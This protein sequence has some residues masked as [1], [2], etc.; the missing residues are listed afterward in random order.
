MIVWTH[1]VEGIVCG[2]V[3]RCR[4]LDDDQRQTAL[5]TVWLELPAWDESRPIQ[6][7]LDSA[8]RRARADRGWPGEHPAGVARR[9]RAAVI[10]AAERLTGE[11]SHRASGPPRT[12]IAREQL[13]LVLADADPIVAGYSAERIA[14]LGSSH[15]RICRGLGVSDDA[16]SRH[17]AAARQRIG[18]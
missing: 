3:S 17:L 8:C 12:A 14:D 10:T 1:E 5:V 7:L 2:W 15:H 11:E 16:V 4:T 9:R 6:W 13:A 18:A